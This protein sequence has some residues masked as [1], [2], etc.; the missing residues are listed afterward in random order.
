MRDTRTAPAVFTFHLTRHVVLVALLGLVAIV[1][2]LLAPL[3]AR[4]GDN[5]G[6]GVDPSAKPWICH[7]VEGAGETGDGW[8]LIDPS[9]DSSHIDEATGVGQHTRKDGSTDRYAV[10]NGTSWTCS[11][12]PT[13]PTTGTTSEP[14]TSEPS[15]TTS[16]PTGT[17]PATEPSGTTG[18]EAPQTGATEPPTGSTSPLAPAGTPQEA[19]TVAP[20]TPVRAAPEVGT[21]EENVVPRAQTD[22]ADLVGVGGGPAGWAALQ[23][24]LVGAGVLLLLASGL[25]SVRRQR[26]QE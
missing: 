7:P 2:G 15:E 10:W 5:Q 21:V 18:T 8:N 1:V 25:L 17:T 20:T 3:S 24:T 19:A 13:S 26:A 9:K 12:G 6:G 22:G 4:A 14:T 11:G 16:E 23:A